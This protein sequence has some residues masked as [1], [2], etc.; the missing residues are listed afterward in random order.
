MNTRTFLAASAVAA[1]VALAPLSSANAATKP[2]V[3]TS[4]QGTFTTATDGT[5]LATGASQGVPFDGSF[6]ATLHADDGTLPAPGECEPGYGTLRI[7]GSRGRYVQL[8]GSG[9]VCGQWLQP[10][11][12]VTQVFTGRY[13]VPSTTE[14]KLRGGDGWFEI[15]LTVDGRA[16][17]S[18]YDS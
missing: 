13:A 4:G 2:L 7:E 9:Q 10:P 12:V 5:V 15:R 14:R 1:A 17:V 11:S 6:T 18:A 16:V 3:N 8:I